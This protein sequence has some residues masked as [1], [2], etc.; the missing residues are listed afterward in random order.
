M[1]AVESESHLIDEA[2]EGDR[3]S[4]AQLLLLHYDA[5]YRHID[6]RIS[7]ICRAC[8]VPKTYCSKRLCE[9][10][11]RS[12]HLNRGMKT[13]FEVGSRPSPTIWCV[14]PRSGGAVN[15]ERGRESITPMHR[16]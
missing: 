9:P 1:S 6:T 11:M 12:P 7:T 3:A 4:L 5:L 8:Y 2:I 14:T 15:V 16:P 10:L 13:P